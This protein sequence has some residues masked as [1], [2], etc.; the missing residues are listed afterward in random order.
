MLDLLMSMVKDIIS[1][2]NV[3]AEKIY[4]SFYMAVSEE[5]VFKNSLRHPSVLLGFE[6]AT[7]KE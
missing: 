4:S 2:F 6:V 7:L 3:N 1:S 5:T